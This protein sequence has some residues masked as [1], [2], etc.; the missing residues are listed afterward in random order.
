M[1]ADTCMRTGEA[2]WQAQ[3]ILRAGHLRGA[4]AN[5]KVVWTQAHVTAL[6]EPDSIQQLVSAMPGPQEDG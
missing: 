6:K 2:Q 5:D 4:H 1:D 3:I